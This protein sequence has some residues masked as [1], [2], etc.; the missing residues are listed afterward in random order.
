MSTIIGRVAHERSREPTATRRRGAALEHAIH[1]AVL[2]ELASVGYA[3]LTMEGVA[4]RAHTGKAAL[5][6]RWP[7]KKELVL[8]ALLHVLP[9]PR[10]IAPSKSIR[11]NLIAAL[12]IV[13]DTLAGHAAYPRVEVMAELLRDPELRN[14]FGTMVIEPRLQLIQKL[15]LNS[16]Q[17]GEIQ[18]GQTTSLITQTGPALVLLAFL[19]SGKRPSAAELTQIVDTIV[20]PLLGGARRPKPTM[21]TKRAR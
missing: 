3:E 5:Y 15:L 10:D 2:G 21:P 19:R 17:C 8:E 14:A 7:S 18:P 9:D 11:D 1:R 12:T 20:M 6:R 16:A 4:R 13:A